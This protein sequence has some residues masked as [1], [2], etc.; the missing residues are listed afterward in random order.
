MDFGIFTF[1]LQ[2]GLN[3][4]AIYCLMAIAIILVFTTTR[5]LFVAQ[6]DFL[7]LGALTLSQ[8]QLGRVPGTV[9]ILAGLALLAF[10][11]EG[12][13]ALRER[14]RRRALRAVLFC[15]LV[16]ALVGGGVAWFSGKEL[17]LAIDILATIA[18]VGPIGPLL[19]RIA[20]QPL[21]D[22]SIL[23][24][25]VVATAVHFVIISLS[26]IFFGAEGWRTPALTDAQFAL[27]P[28]LISGQVIAIIV[29]SLLLIVVLFLFFSN[30]VY[31]KSL[32]ATASNRVGAR[33]MGISTAQSG[34]LSF[35][36]A[37]AIGCV[38]GI[39]IGSITTIYYDTGLVLTL[40]GLIA[41]VFG[42]LASFPAAAAG[43]VIL[44]LIESYSAFFASAYKEIILFSLL[45]PLLMWRF[46]LAGHQDLEEEA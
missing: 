36:M 44:G 3:S 22:K 27:G 39:L 2:D 12:A 43:A 15:L 45:I 5:V 32:I 38:S 1:L 21:A 29:T 11:M 14:S 46:V 35:A 33:L 30:S 13:Q 31:G 19:Y 23:V 4:A 42:G 28:V 24:L 6:G 34:M 16:P 9:W 18:L 26:L 37:S 20:F 40:K 41:A 10:A 8:L 25:M 7:V 17:G